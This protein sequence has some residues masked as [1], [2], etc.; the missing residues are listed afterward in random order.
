MKKLVDEYN[1]IT[2]AQ[3]AAYRMQQATD[4]AAQLQATVA[5][6]REA[7]L[8]NINV[9]LM[10]SKRLASL[11]TEATVRLQNE[12]AYLRSFVV[13]L[14]VAIIVMVLCVTKVI[15]F[16]VATAI[17]GAVAVILVSALIVSAVQNANRYRM[18]YP[19]R[20]WPLHTDTPKEDEDDCGCDP[21]RS[22]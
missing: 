5:D 1:R 18:L 17:V 14:C 21:P 8:R 12:C 13:A 22:A 20:E 6:S 19:E 9:D 7:Q 11:N 4:Y 16:P 15:S 2:D 10:T 3:G